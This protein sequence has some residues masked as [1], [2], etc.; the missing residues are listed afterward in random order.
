M[1]QVVSKK[2]HPPL[3]RVGRKVASRKPWSLGGTKN[4]SKSTVPLPGGEG[5]TAIKGQWSEWLALPWTLTL[6]VFSLNPPS[7]SEAS[8]IIV[9]IA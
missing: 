6:V 8:V 1:A 3:Q 2:E 9:P 7:D 5:G 4:S